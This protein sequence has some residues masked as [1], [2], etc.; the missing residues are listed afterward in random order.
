[1]SFS[2]T[3]Q[4]W[5][6][7]YATAGGGAAAL[8]GLLFVGLSLHLRA[9]VSHRDIRAL[10]RVTLSDFFVVLVL[11]LFI[12]AP[13]GGAAATGYEVGGIGL[14]G[15]LLMVRPA[16]QGMRGRR[17]GSPWFRVLVFRFGLSGLGYLGLVATGA[18]LA[19]TGDYRDALYGLLVVVVVLLMVGVRNTWDLLVTVAEQGPGGAA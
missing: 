4:G 12:L 18:A 9:V 8:A 19:G 6:D 13:S 11:A 14:V 3:V 15:F 7:V 1:M 17:T 10:A 16:V 5:H 2:D